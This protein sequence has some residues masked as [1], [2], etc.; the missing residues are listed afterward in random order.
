METTHDERRSLVRA[1]LLSGLGASALS[2]I[3]IAAGS[4]AKH[5]HAAAGLNGPSQWIWGRQAAHE[6]ELSWKHT[7]VG[8]AIHQAS[9]WLWSSLFEYIC[10]KNRAP[11]VQPSTAQVMATAAGVTGL[12]YVVDYHMTPKRLEPGFDKHLSSRSM[13][14][15]YAAFAAG[16]ALTHLWREAALRDPSRAGLRGVLHRS[17]P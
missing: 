13:V 7:V 12:A 14:L 1:A 9:A 5:G 2:S 4:R 15:T 17:T 3:A 10:H 16:L 6:R 11:D 8:T